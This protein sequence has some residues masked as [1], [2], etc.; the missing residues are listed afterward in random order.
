MI[1][2]VRVLHKL[3]YHELSYALVDKLLRICLYQNSRNFYRAYVYGKK[4]GQYRSSLV[5][6]L[7][8][9]TLSG[10]NGHYSAQYYKEL[11]SI[12][13]RN[14]SIDKIKALNY[15]L[16]I[17]EARALAEDEVQSGKLN[18]TEY[19]SFLNVLR[20]NRSTL[21]HS[22]VAEACQSS[23]MLD[24]AWRARITKAG[25]YRFQGTA[26]GEAN[27]KVFIFVDDVLLKTTNVL[28]DGRF[29]FNLKKETIK[30][31]SVQP[32]VVI[33]G[34]T[35]VVKPKSL[36]K[37]FSVLC[38]TRGNLLS[39]LEDGYFVN[40]KGKLS[41]PLIESP[42]YLTKML[43]EYRKYNEFIAEALGYNV[44]FVYGSLLG[45]VRGDGVIYHDD[46]FDMA[47]LSRKTNP[48]DVIDEMVELSILMNQHG[49]KNRVSINGIIKPASNIAI[50]IYAAWFQDGSLYM[51]NTTKLPLTEG[52]ITPLKSLEFDG[53]TVLVP[54][55]SEKFLRLKYG[56]S[57]RVPDPG[58]RRQMA[59]GAKDVLS[60]AKPSKEQ[61]ELV[62]NS[63]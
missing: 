38:G 40:K 61:I 39:Y 56:E 30:T 33:V 20:V 45:L 4:T 51:Q 6:L 14:T 50:D 19:N 3:G 15:S 22:G 48:Q 10:K 54:K 24:G 23:K 26:P 17:D 46:D 5:H 7:K 49:L 57:W 9:I 35:T 8:A 11:E 41:R 32:H 43:S 63:A 62:K 18:T 55:D 1:A 16:C 28:D 37:T 58:Y 25:N 34:Y 13:K 2:V 21:D 42:N 12:F 27:G 52:D 53:Q 29:S 36:H 44:W 31:F 60:I 47:Y 59:P